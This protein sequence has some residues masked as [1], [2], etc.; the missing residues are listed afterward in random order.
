M[1]FGC[2]FARSL[3]LSLQEKYD[4]DDDDDKNNNTVN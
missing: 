3:L 4:D 1:E 2:V